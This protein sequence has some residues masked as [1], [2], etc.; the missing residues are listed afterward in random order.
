M[1]LFVKYSVFFVTDKTFKGVSV[2]G[3]YA[4][5]STKIGQTT[6]PLLGKPMFVPEDYEFFKQAEIG[7][8]HSAQKWMREFKDFGDGRLVLEAFAGAGILTLVYLSEG[9]EPFVIEQQSG[10]VRALRKNLKRYSPTFEKDRCFLADNMTILPEVPSDN[11]DIKA[12]DLD[13][14]N[15]CIPQI[16]ESARILR[17]GLLFVSSGDILPICRFK[18]YGFI[19]KRYGISFKGSWRNFPKDVIY[20]FIRQTFRE[21]N[22]KT[23]LVGAFVWPTVCRLCVKIS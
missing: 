4:G 10:L 2:M 5:N 16:R 11:P 23:E 13:C 18:K 15:N 7:K 14:Y 17:K 9:Y 22:K 1:L 6:H 20:K 12:V 8:L 21:Q 3:K 19:E